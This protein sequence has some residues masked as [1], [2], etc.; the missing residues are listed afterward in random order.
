MSIR[1]LESVSQEGEWTT[2]VALGDLA[3]TAIG[4]F[5]YAGS[6]VLSVALDAIDL[7]SIQSRQVIVGQNYINET[8]EYDTYYSGSL[9]EPSSWVEVPGVRSNPVLI[10][11]DVEIIWRST[12][13]QYRT[14]MSHSFGCSN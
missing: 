8:Y 11:S 6:K 9:N 13:T 3:A 10:G 2:N 14:C 5:P 7:V 1:R 4:T 12:E